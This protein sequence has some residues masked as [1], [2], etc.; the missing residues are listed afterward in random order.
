MSPYTVTR[1]MHLPRSHHGKVLARRGPTPPPAAAPPRISKLMAL[2]IHLDD[3]VARG[4][5]P[6]YA[7]A[8]RLGQVS[9]A[10][11]TQIV[12]L[13]L[14][15]PDI[16]EELLFLPKTSREVG[17]LNTRHLQPLA[18][19]PDWQCQRARWKQLKRQLPATIF[20]GEDAQP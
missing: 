6:D 20:T 17:G 18:R 2:A 12:N 1:R 14:L 8:A 4:Q 11:I 9:R 5:L 15:A 13:T 19:E 16:Q 7:T 10:R 3:L